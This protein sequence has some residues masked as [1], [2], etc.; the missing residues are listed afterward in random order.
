MGERNHNNDQN[1]AQNKWLA[2]ENFLNDNWVSLPSQSLPYTCTYI[3]PKDLPIKQ[4]RKKDT[5]LFTLEEMMLTIG[6][7][8]SA[9]SRNKLK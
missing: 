6:I 2:K 3:S 1:M 7:A 8:V 5:A 9:N 4:V